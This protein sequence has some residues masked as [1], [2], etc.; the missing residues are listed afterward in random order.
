MG[1]QTL[2]GKDKWGPQQSWAHSSVML[3]TAPR[4][5]RHLLAKVKLPYL[6]RKISPQKTLKIYRNRENPTYDFSGS[7]ALNLIQRMKI[8][9][10]QCTF[11][12]F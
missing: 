7:Q 5:R 8:F 9:C 12:L 4:E 1:A 10:C 3:P 11:L 2:E 6:G